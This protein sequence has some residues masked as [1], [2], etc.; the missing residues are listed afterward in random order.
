MARAVVAMAG[1]ARAARDLA[2]GTGAFL[3]ALAEAGVAHVE[4]IDSDPAALAVA[5]VAAP[6]ARLVL[7]DGLAPRERIAVVVGNPP[8]V[9]PERQDKAM[10]RALQARFPWI[11]GR[12]DLAVPF[13][14]VALEQARDA[15]ALV[16]PWGLLTQPYAASLRRRWLTE[17]AITGLEGPLA[18]PGATVQVARIALRVGGAPR[19]LPNGI[20]PRELLALAACPLDPM[21]QPGDAERIRRIRAESIS[22]GDVAEVDTG[23]VAHGPHGGKAALLFDEP[24][25]GRVP[26]VDAQD[27]LDGRIRWLAYRPHRMHRAKRPALFEGPKLLVQRVRGHGP[28]R[29]WIDRTG[30][31]A[32]HT[33]TVVRPI[34]PRIDLE[35][36]HEVLTSAQTEWILRVE[37]GRRLDLYPSEIRG[38]PAPRSWLYTPVGRAED[39]LN[40]P[41]P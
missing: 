18:F 29:A 36:L 2:C 30:L 35:A 27:L 14:A 12:F 19:R 41:A 26:Y 22:I 15:L 39:R 5:S 8:F 7:G 25:P 23:V 38:I 11:T 21:I 4:G 37:S 32:G 16:V 9:P 10:R 6:R 17:H 33:L 40:R 20:E 34:D 28:V 13:A 24:G 31:Y 1:R 3:V